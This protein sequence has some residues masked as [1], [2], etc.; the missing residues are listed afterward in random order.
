MLKYNEEIKFFRE[1]TRESELKER[2]KQQNAK[3]QYDYIKKL[4]K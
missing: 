3:R 4:E 1:K 2:K